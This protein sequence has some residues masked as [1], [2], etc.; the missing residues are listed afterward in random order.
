MRSFWYQRRNENKNEGA[1]RNQ[2]NTFKATRTLGLQV[3]FNTKTL[4]KMCEKKA[5]KQ[6]EQSG[7]Y[8]QVLNAELVS[9]HVNSRQEDGLH[10]VVTQLVGWQM[11]S[12]ENLINSKQKECQ[13]KELRWAISRR[14]SPPRQQ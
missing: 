2:N 5:G 6:A 8:L 13:W 10:L 4:S 14:L 7:R 9:I 12:N 3:R 11:G 1:A